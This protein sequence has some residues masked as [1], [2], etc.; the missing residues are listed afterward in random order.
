MVICLSINFSDGPLPLARSGLG[1]GFRAVAKP[2]HA[3]TGGDRACME[4]RPTSFYAQVRSHLRVDTP[5]TSFFVTCDR[6]SL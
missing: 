3:L 5:P 6:T 1:W 2:R 4:A